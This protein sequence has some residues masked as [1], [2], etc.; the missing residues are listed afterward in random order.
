MKA[1]LTIKAFSNA[2]AIATRACVTGKPTMPILSTIRISASSEKKRVMLACTT[3]DI[4]IET[5]LACEV[6]ESG[7]FCVSAPIFTQIIRALSGET[8]ELSTVKTQIKIESGPSLFRLHTL[9][10]TEFPPAPELKQTDI[11]SI[12]FK[13]DD[14]L[15]RLLS[16]MPA[17]STDETRFI[18]NG[19]FIDRG[20]EAF[21]FVGTDGRRLH[22]NKT[23]QKSEERVHMILPVDS[24]AKLI[25]LLDFGGEAHL[26]FSASGRHIALRIDREEGE[27][28]FFSKV[29]E[30]AY[31]N[32]AQVIPQNHNKDTVKL[33]RSDFAQALRRVALSASE[34]T[35]S[36]Q[37]TVRG[38]EITLTASSPDFG[39]AK[40]EVVCENAKGIE[41]KLAI[42]PR[43]VIEALNAVE[44]EHVVM[45]VTNDVSP[46]IL[47]IGN[48]L[49]VIMPIRLS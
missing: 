5:S 14:L 7:E 13:Q 34:K 42:N 28:M 4:R 43:F 11:Q 33:N 41:A 39:D 46:M 35:S 32:Y 44:D 31:P 36:I 2:L 49:T 26:Q 23:A 12:V 6:T 19:I 38:K 17:A 45:K 8:V 16:V 21:S 47:S 15:A 48:L 20:L 3:L 27:V 10:A 22:V 29:V 1:K 30:G 9:P 25:S 24:N 40:E 37:I 18:L